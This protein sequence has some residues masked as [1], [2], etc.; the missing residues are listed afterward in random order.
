MRQSW[1]SPREA[2]L[3]RPST[4]C[5]STSRSQAPDPK[6]AMHS[7]LP[8]FIL[9]RLCARPLPTKSRWS[10]GETSTRTTHHKIATGSGEGGARLCLWEQSGEGFT[11]ETALSAHL[12][13]SEIL[14]MRIWALG[15]PG[16]SLSRA[17]PFLHSPHTPACT[18]C[19]ICLEPAH[20]ELPYPQA[21][22]CYYQE[23]R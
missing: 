5:G 18:F 20:W 9:S 19:L 1:Q 4:S 17:H 3:S 12:T 8:S 10:Y 16:R 7:S 13:G 2:A 21:C 11:E 6:V 14:S 15:W 22:V 23:A